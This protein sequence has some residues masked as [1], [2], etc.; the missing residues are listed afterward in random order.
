MEALLRIPA[1]ARA[2]KRH[3]KIIRE[4]VALLK[5]VVVPHKPKRDTEINAPTTKK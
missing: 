3:K 2:V 1:I 4:D 5:K